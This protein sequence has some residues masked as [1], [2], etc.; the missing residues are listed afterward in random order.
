MYLAGG[1][2]AALAY[3]AVVTGHFD[4]EIPMGGASGAISACMG[5]YLLLRGRCR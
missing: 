4:S 2:I 5:M 1:I 3:I